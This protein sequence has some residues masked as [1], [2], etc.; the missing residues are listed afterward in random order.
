MEREEITRSVLPGVKL[1]D[2]IGDWPIVADQGYFYQVLSQLSLDETWTDG[3][4]IY[5]VEPGDVI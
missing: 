1:S 2:Y 3:Q 5:Y 4:I